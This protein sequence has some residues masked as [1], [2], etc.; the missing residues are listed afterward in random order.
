MKLCIIQTDLVLDGQGKV[1][2]IAEP[3][4]CPRTLRLK[5][6]W[7]LLSLK[8]EWLCCQQLDLYLFVAYIG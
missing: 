5:I 3:V 8:G 6:S 2:G 7:Q 1:I 4:S